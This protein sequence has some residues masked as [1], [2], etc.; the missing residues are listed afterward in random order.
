MKILADTNI[1]IKFNR[2]LP[3]PTEVETILET[4]L[5][6]RFIS[7][8]TIVELFRLWKSGRVP[9]DPDAWLDEALK[10]WT[11][12]PINFGIARQS[13]IWDWPHKDPADRIIAAT[14]KIENVELW[15]TDTLIKK[16][17]GFPQRYFVNRFVVKK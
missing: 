15:H 16:F 1:F 4:D 6:E 17:S 2:R 8:V 3:L 13:A 5:A 9:L 10:S 14:A 11:V 7:A 12:I